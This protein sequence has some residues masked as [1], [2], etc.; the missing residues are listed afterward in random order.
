MSVSAS[1]IGIQ[2]GHHAAQI[3]RLVRLDLV[4]II[5]IPVCRFA[6]LCFVP[7][8]PL[9]LNPLAPQWQAARDLLLFFYKCLLYN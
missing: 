9:G 7:H 2:V 8:G 1:P 3:H 6:V 4:Q 5:W